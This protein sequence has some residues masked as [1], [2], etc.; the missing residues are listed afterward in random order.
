MKAASFSFL[1]NVILRFMVDL[2]IVQ[3]VV[4]KKFT[5]MMFLALCVQHLKA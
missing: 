2:P 1:C 5:T 4:Q 3:P